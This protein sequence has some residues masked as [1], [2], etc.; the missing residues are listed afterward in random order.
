[1]KKEGADWDREES[2][3]CIKSL[4][5]ERKGELSEC[6]KRLLDRVECTFVVS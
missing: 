4:L 1:M 3:G 6:D 2:I 5:G